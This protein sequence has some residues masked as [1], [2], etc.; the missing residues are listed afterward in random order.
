MSSKDQ[1][2]FVLDKEYDC[3]EEELTTIER[4]ELIIK[5]Y[6]TNSDTDDSLTYYFFHKTNYINDIIKILNECVIC[7]PNDVDNNKFILKITNEENYGIFFKSDYDKY[8]K[9]TL[10]F[11]S[12][13]EESVN[14]YIDI[15]QK[16]KKKFSDNKIENIK[17]EKINIV[18][19]QFL[20]FKE[21]LKITYKEM[22]DYSITDLSNKVNEQDK[23]KQLKHDI[24]QNTLKAM[25]HEMTNDKINN[26]INYQK[27]FN[28]IVIISL[29]FM[30]FYIFYYFNFKK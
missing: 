1:K 27:Y 19:K 21:Y 23:E 22:L 14:K 11:P 10:Y 18:N 20:K 6:S 3:C 15:E 8:I 5:Y 29:L 26:F 16:L 13:F 17:Q 12:I 4:N 9:Y 7:M 25:I 2:E 30:Y 24:E 28:K